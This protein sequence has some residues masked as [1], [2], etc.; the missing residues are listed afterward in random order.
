[1]LTKKIKP[2]TIVI[3][4]N[5]QLPYF[6]EGYP[7]A[8]KVAPLET[9]DYSILGKE[10]KVCIERKSLSDLRGSTGNG[11]DRL[12]EEF[13]RMISFEYAAFVTEAYIEDIYSP[14]DYSRMNPDSTY[15][16]LISWGIKYGVQ[17]FFCG[18]R[19]NAEKTV[20]EILEKFNRADGDFITKPNFYRRKDL[21]YL[22]ASAREEA[23]KK[24][25]FFNQL[26][27][28]RDEKDREIKKVKREMRKILREGCMGGS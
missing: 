5:E 12:E 8:V 26:I 11:R 9:G 21:N 18:N 17:V 25:Q 2:F 23:V 24:E 7:C 28:E 10:K 1:M 13:R 19:K 6:F 14:D 20:F 16:T 15:S 3:A 4:G 27:K 22:S